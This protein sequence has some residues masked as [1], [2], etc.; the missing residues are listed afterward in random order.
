MCSA[1]SFSSARSSDVLCPLLLVRQ[2]LRG[3]SVVVF[4]GFPPPARPGDRPDTGAGAM[5]GHQQLRRGPHQVEVAEAE[6]EHVRRRIDRAQGA[7]HGQRMRLDLGRKPQRRHH[8]NA[9]PGDDVLF[10][11]LNAINEVFACDVALHLVL[12]KV[13]GG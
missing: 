3:Q 1:R 12:G 9:V 2:K 7:I 8:L 10:D 13:P 6:E 4:R 5:K 11:S